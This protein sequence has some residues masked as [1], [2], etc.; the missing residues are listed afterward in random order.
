VPRSVVSA[1]VRMSRF[2]PL[3]LYPDQLASLEAAR[4]ASSGNPAGD[5]GFTARP[6]EL[7][8]ARD[9]TPSTDD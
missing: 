7:A 5:L 6:L 4:P 9:S 8:L 1:L 2:A 3:P